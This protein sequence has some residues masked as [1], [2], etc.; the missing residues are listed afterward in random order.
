VI[1]DE[2]TWGSR[3]SQTVGAPRLRVSI[4][5]SISAFLLCLSDNRSQ[6]IR[7]KNAR[8]AFFFRPSPP[9]TSSQLTISLNTQ[10]QSKLLSPK[11]QCRPPF[12]SSSSSPFLLLFRQ[13][14]DSLLLPLRRL[15]LRHH[16]QQQEDKLENRSILL[17]NGILEYF[18]RQ[19]QH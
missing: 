14:K 6:S 2:L 13:S 8:R 3:R 1:C 10:L 12:D 16:H 9:I 19:Q 4:L 11:Q 18:N 7:A 17:P 5:H 15:L